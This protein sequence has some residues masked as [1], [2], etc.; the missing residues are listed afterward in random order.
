MY[1][2]VKSVQGHGTEASSLQEPGKQKTR[3]KR[4]YPGIKPGY[5]DSI[6][7]SRQGKRRG[8]RGN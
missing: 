8:R 3:Q 4:P 5:G 7:F 1:V 2:H 6:I